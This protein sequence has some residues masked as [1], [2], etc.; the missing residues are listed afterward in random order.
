ML[1]SNVPR[2]HFSPPVH[3]SFCVFCTF[4]SLQDCRTD[5]TGYLRNAGPSRTL[6]FPPHNRAQTR[7]KR[8]PVPQPQ[9]ARALCTVQCGGEMEVGFGESVIQAHQLIDHTLEVES[10][11]ANSHMTTKNTLELI[12]TMAKSQLRTRVW[13][14][15]RANL[16]VLR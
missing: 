8:F 15:H 4:C 12:V 11:I 2:P 13:N 1:P 7:H 10:S 9:P 3:S 6:P 5:C 14:D 16:I